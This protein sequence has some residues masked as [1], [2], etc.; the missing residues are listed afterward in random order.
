MVFEGSRVLTGDVALNGLR[1]VDKRNLVD[2]R[3]GGVALI[4]AVRLIG[5]DAAAE[6][7]FRSRQWEKTDTAEKYEE[8][9][10]KPAPGYDEAGN[11]IDRLELEWDYEEET[12]RLTEK[13]IVDAEEDE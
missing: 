7:C 13:L 11:E 9:D 2:A 12:W 10:A 4:Q 8:A 1:D 6:R 3:L 5:C